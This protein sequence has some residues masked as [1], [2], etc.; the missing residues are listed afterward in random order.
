MPQDFD[1]AHLTYAAA[2]YLPEDADTQELADELTT[3]DQ[4]MPTNRHVRILDKKGTG[5]IS[6]TPLTA[7]PE[8]QQV[9]TLKAEVGGRWAS[10]SRK[11]ILVANPHMPSTLRPYRVAQRLTAVW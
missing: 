1:H 11:V 4:A 8:P 6:L 2:L 9:S 3:L 10:A 5:W 7:Q